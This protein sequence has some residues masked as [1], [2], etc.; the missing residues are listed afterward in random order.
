MNFAGQRWQSFVC[1]SVGTFP[2]CARIL[3]TVPFFVRMTELGADVE[4][5]DAAGAGTSS[6]GD[7]STSADIVGGQR[8]MGAGQKVHYVGFCVINRPVGS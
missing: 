7:S 4:A 6:G 3:E 8:E 5:R 2:L 1:G